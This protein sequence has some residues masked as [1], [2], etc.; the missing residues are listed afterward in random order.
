MFD[1]PMLPFEEFGVPAELARK[2]AGSDTDSTE[3]TKRITEDDLLY[4]ISFGSGSSGNSGYIGTRN[5]GL[6]IDAGLRADEITAGLQ[7]AGIP[8]TTVKG[9]LLT[10]DHSD[11]VRSTYTLLRNNKHLKLF[12]GNRTMEGILKRTSISKRIREYHIPIFLET[13]FRMLDFEITP[14]EVPHDSFQNFGYSIEFRG[15]HFVIAT[16]V[17]AITDRIRHY[18]S[19][20]DYLV[21]ESNFDR[22]MLIQGRYPEYLKHRIMSGRGHLDNALA[23][24]FLKEIWSP[25]LKHIFLCHLSQDN[26]TPSKALKAS[27]DVLESLN[28]KVGNGLNSLSDRQA[29]TQLTVLPRF[30]STPL[31]VFRE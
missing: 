5:G 20:A 15:R 18:S 10:H 23:A 6:I 12:C 4:Y 25:R 22:A 29:A 28:I 1:H 7:R 31:Y 8:M 11:H 24:G 14:F 9:I 16:D 19:Q 3:K 17:G 26:N 21:L 2:P 30:D 27:K 13:P